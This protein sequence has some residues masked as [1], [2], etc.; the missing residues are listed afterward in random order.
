MTYPSHG[1]AGISKAHLVEHQPNALFQMTGA[2]EVRERDQSI[3]ARP[4]LVAVPRCVLLVGQRFE[5]TKLVE[6]RAIRASAAFGFEPFDCDN[7]IDGR[8]TSL[9]P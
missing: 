5:R 2:Y 7:R 9:R 3:R 6:D 4:R 8:A 1:L